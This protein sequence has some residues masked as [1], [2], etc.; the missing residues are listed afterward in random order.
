MKAAFWFVPCFRSPLGVAL[1]LVVATSSALVGC[2]ENTPP[3]PISVEF[4]GVPPTSMMVGSTQSF[5]V[6]ISNDFSAKGVIWSVTC[7]LANSNKCGSFSSTATQSNSS[8]TYRAPLSVNVSGTATVTVTA[9]LVADSTKSV[10][11]T[12]AIT[13]PNIS[14]A[15][16]QTTPL[17]NALQTGI[18]IPLAAVVTG[19]NLNQ[20]VTWSCT[21][22]SSCGSFTAAATPSGASTTYVAPGAIP[23][24]QTVTITAAS[25]TDPGDYCSLSLFISAEPT[26]LAAGTYVFSLAGTDSKGSYYVAGAFEVTNGTITGGEQDFRDPARTRTDTITAGSFYATDDGNLWITLNTSDTAIGVN[27]VETLSV[28]LVS[29]SHALLIEYDTSGSASGTLDQQTNKT[30]PSGG[31][32]FFTAGANSQN[33]PAAIGGVVNIDGYGTISGNGSV[34][35]VSDASLLAPSPN[36]TFAA[37]SV[38]SPDSLGRVVFNL[39]PSSGSAIPQLNL[40]GYLV[41][42]AAIQLVETTDAYGGVTGGTALTQSG[43]T[44]NFSAGSISGSNYVFTATGL[45]RGVGPLQVAGLLSPQSN[46]SPI[47]EIVSATFS[48]GD[49]SPQTLTAGSY[50]I[51]PTGRVTFTGLTGT[52]TNSPFNY[53]LQLYLTGDGHGVLI[54]MNP[55]EAIGGL[56]FRQA[57]P[58]SLNLN[59]LSGPYAMNVLQITKSAGYS[60]QNAVGPILAD[61]AGDFVGFA[62]FNLNNIDGGIPQEQNDVSLG[63]LVATNTNGIFSGQSVGLYL[64]APSTVCNFRYYQIDNTRIALVETDGVEL[65]IGYFLLQQ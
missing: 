55:S 54:S 43:N 61:G 51:D 23:T 40:V 11:V 26:T 48:V 4:G 19:D 6:I 21:P 49:V 25:V 22:I 60:T 13:A 65:T 18:S 17:P 2:G 52:S 8:T 10:S 27:G 44:G 9:T 20:G 46:G 38:S 28:T 47:G 42:G 58:S 37:S 33:L 56:A 64:S 34:F 1:L 5:A 29:S 14:V 12:I 15:F 16:S 63:G 62:D 31:Y 57:D 36:Q 3:P 7:N 41:D 24:H 45:I 30:M 53:N 32:A 50:A 35:D 59:P 39:V